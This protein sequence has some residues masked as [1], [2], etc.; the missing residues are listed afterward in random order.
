[1][2]L[3]EL[4]WA[5]ALRVG[6]PVDCGGQGGT[7]AEALDVV[8]SVAQDSVS[9]ALVLASQRLLIEAVVHAQN[10]A[11]RD[12]H[13]PALLAG[14]IGGSCAA[15]WPLQ[16]DVTPLAARNTGRG[17]RMSGRLPAIPNLDAPWFLL[18]LPVSFGLGRTYSLVMLRSEEDGLRFYD[19]G[20]HGSALELAN[21]FLREDEILSSDGPAAVAHL[22]RFSSG[23][24][25]AALAG[26]RRGVGSSDTAG[27]ASDA[28]ALFAE[29]RAGFAARSQSGC[30]VCEPA[31]SA[32][33]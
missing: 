29:R 26:V 21:V 13:L 28:E 20:E 5:G 25:A 6:V 8:A 30:W 2:L 10:V 18:T 14:E 11:I 22:A 17:W 3:R 9:K 24:Q 27:A 32:T 1:M 16:A 31:R 19:A 4:A 33:C 23:L 15:S 7:L 12:Y